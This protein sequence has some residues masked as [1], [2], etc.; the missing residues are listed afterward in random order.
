MDNQIDSAVE[1]EETTDVT[2]TGME[3]NGKMLLKKKR[4]A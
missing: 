1:T 3:A 4:S 2:T